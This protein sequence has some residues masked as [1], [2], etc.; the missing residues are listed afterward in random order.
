[1]DKI[2]ANLNKDKKIPDIRP[3]DIVRVYQKIKEGKKERE[4]A[5][6]GVVI[7]RTGGKTPGASFVVRKISQGIGIERKFP[8]YSP[9]LIKIQIK[10]RSKVKRAN[11]SYLRNVRQIAK[12]LKDKKIEPFEES[13]LPEIK[14][15]KKAPTP[16]EGEV[17]VPTSSVENKKKK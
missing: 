14:K 8:I 6:E 10:K 7:K 11:L 3:G 5:F 13:L 15:E 16:T 9:L 17:G 4:Q 2:I 12:K 1:M